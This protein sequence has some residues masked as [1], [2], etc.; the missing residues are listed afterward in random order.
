MANKLVYYSQED[1]RWASQLYSNRRDPKQTIGTSACG[2][3]CFSMM[4]SSL[5][6]REVLPPEAA[7]WSVDHGY[8]TDN[9]GTAWNFFAAIS[10]E[11][12]L[13]CKQTGSLDEAKKALASGAPVIAAMGPGHVTGGG[14]YISL[15]GIS[16]KWIDVFD[17]NHDNIKYGNDGL[18]DQG[19]RNDGKVKIDEAVFRREAKQ[20]WI[21]NTIEEV[22]PKM[23]MK[24][25]LAVIKS[26]GSLWGLEPTKKGKDEIHRQ[27]NAVRKAHGIPLQ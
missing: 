20:Y 1:K 18:V 15:V 22:K 5:T 16:G 19:V 2:T 25:A 13:S 23:E 12:G 8:R 7:K 4:A 26:L 24:D 3:T 6:D 27:A 11:Y 21:F 14:H 9:N 17:P 10:K